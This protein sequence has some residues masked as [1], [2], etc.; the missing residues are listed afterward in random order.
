MLLL[1]LLDAE[2][3]IKRSSAHQDDE[4][5]TDR[6]GKKRAVSRKKQQSL[7]RS[8]NVGGKDDWSK[9][10]KMCFAD[11]CTKYSITGEACISYGANKNV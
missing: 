7:K 5:L 10:K 9:D 3:R 11:G 1:L 8:E 2:L 6:A 4:A